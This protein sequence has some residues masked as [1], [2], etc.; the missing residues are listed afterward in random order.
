TTTFWGVWGALIEIPEKAGFPATLGYSVWALTM[1]P[2]ALVTLKIINW[3][4]EYDRRSVLLGLVI[5]FTGAGGQLILFEALRIGPAYLVFPII[6]LSPVV[7]ILLSYWFLNERASARGWVG[8]VLALIAIPLLSY[9]P[10]ENGGAVSALW[11]PL[12]LLVFF[13]WGFQAFVMKF[14]NER[15]KAESIFFYMMLTGILLIPI[16]LVMTDF[17]QS[18]NWGFNGPYL[19][20]MIQILNAVGALCLVYA[21]RYGKAIIVSPLT[22]AGAPVITIII[23]LIIYMVIPHPIIVTGMSVAI[24]AAFLMA[25]ESEE[26]EASSDS[27]L[28]HGEVAN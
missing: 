27:Q 25:I 26:E 8:I 23:S 17:S 5:G 20:A 14:A 24:I 9:Q 1:I 3:K 18:I 11:I 6:S 28:E 15:M 13:A 7:T 10:P 16:A 21:F 4:L 22:N 12:A 2:P 19:A